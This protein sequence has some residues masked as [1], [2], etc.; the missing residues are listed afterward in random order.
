MTG[1]E[2]AGLVASYIARRFESRG[3]KVYREVEIGKTIVGRSRRIDIFCVNEESRQAFAI[4]CKF[5]DTKGTVDQKIL[6]AMDDL[7]A[8]S[9]AGCIVYAGKGFSTGVLHVLAASSRAAY[10]LPSLGQVKSSPQ[11]VQLDQ[12]LATHFG[13]WDVLVDKKKPV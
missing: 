8:L 3:L 2:Y 11:T 6:Y 9:L 5:Q 13:W 1:A 4:E 7:R 12:V 10:C